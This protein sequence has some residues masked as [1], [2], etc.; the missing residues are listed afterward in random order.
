LNPNIIENKFLEI[1][2]IKCKKC[3]KQEKLWSGKFGDDYTKRND[4]D[5][6][7]FYKKEFGITR[8]ALNK[9]FLKDVSK[10]AMILE[11][12]CNSGKQLVLLKKMGFKNCWGIDVNRLALKRAKNKGLSVFHSSIRHSFYDNEMFDLVMTNGL[13]IHIAR[14]DLKKAINE[15]CRISSKYIFCCEYYTPK[16]KEIPYRKQRNVLWSDNFLHKFL[17]WDHV[18]LVAYQF[19]RHGKTKKLSMMF[20]LEKQPKNNKIITLPSFRIF[21]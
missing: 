12:G 19:L 15:I 16:R 9:D 20:L 8:T 3:G 5:L 18:R 4:I 6:D 11:I 1:K 17:L 2:M 10:E 21:D 13:L 7:I 14:K